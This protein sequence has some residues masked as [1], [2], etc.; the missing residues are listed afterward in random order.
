MCLVLNQVLGVR[1]VHGAAH[2]NAIGIKLAEHAA[3]GQALIDG[4]LLPTG[5]TVFVDVENPMF[6]AR[7]PLLWLQYGSMR[8]RLLHRYG[9]LPRA[10]VPRSQH[11][12]APRPRPLP[13]HLIDALSDWGEGAGAVGSPR[14][15]AASSG[16]LTPTLTLS[17]PSSSDGRESP[18]RP[19]AAQAAPSWMHDRQE[20]R[21]SQAAAAPPPRF[22]MGSRPTT[23]P[24]VTRPEGYGYPVTIRVDAASQPDRAAQAASDGAAA[25]ASDAVLPASSDA[26]CTLRS[27]D[28]TVC[29]KLSNERLQGLQRDQDPALAAILQLD[30]P[31]TSAS[32]SCMPAVRP[33]AAHANLL[34]SSLR[35]ARSC[36]AVADVQGLFGNGCESRLHADGVSSSV[37]DDGGC[38]ACACAPMRNTPH[39]DRSALLREAQPSSPQYPGHRRKRRYSVGDEH[40]VVSLADLLGG[41]KMHAEE[42]CSVDGL[43]MLQPTAAPPVIDAPAT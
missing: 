40:N 39:D 24:G 32:E 11:R 3:G 1:L 12:A 37:H 15:V 22:S 38:N 6:D 16:G 10:S 20:H 13:F 17:L 30:D 28:S 21:G 26:C 25:R 23:V 4:A 19:R 35:R 31:L 42:P 43:S 27:R 9:D 34:A 29:D 41:P 5:D 36:S 14:G 18:Q 7:N 2:D 33:A 8:R